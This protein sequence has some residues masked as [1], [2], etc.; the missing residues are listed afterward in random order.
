VATLPSATALALSGTYQPLPTPVACLAPQCL[1]CRCCTV[2]VGLAPVDNSRGCACPKPWEPANA[3][4]STGTGADAEPVVAPA[5]AALTATPIP[6]RAIRPT[7][8]YPPC[9]R[10]S[11]AVRSAPP[12][13]P[14]LSTATGCVRRHAGRPLGEPRYRR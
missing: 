14:L 12:P 9:R 7:P 5:N 2:T 10:L 1:Q 3:L 13:P 8:R 4:P 11:L 6:A